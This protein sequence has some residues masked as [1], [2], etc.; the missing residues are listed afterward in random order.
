MTKKNGKEIYEPPKAINLSGLG[1][2]GQQV[3]PL[4]TCDLGNWPYAD[5]D[6]G[7]FF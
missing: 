2:N 3:G 7:F 4:G 1:A 6:N 5:C